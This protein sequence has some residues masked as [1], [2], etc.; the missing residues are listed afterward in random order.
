MDEELLSQLLTLLLAGGAVLISMSR[1][2]VG[3]FEA[4]TKQKLVATELKF[5]R[6]QVQN[7]REKT[8]VETQDL[9]NSVLQQYM[10]EKDALQVRVQELEVGG[11]EE[12]LILTNEI[13]NLRLQ[14]QDTRAS[15]QQRIE[16]LEA[17]VKQK[18]RRIAELEQRS[19]VEVVSNPS[20]GT[21]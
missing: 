18:D 14:L 15:L 20:D 17:V 11:A 5:L 13:H 8:D 3:R 1:M 9:V 10:D 7:M 4:S 19:K 12:R 6:Q 2:L 21:Q 16:E